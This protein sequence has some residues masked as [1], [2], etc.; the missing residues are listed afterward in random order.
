LDPKQK[1]CLY[2]FKELSG[3]G[4]GF[5]LLQGLFQKNEWNDKPLFEQTDLLALSIAADI[6][7][8]LDEN[9]VLAYLGLKVL[10]RMQGVCRLERLFGV[11]KQ[12]IFQPYPYGSLSYQSYLF[13][14]YS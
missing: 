14:I 9:R 6:V 1:N 3:C 8:V 5:K 2:P 10:L 7:Q 11:G 12:T 4:V 13:L